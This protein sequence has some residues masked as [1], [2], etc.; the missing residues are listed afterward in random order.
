MCGAVGG[1][2]PS[3]C[4]FGLRLFGIGVFVVDVDL[5]LMLEVSLGFSLGRFAVPALEKGCSLPFD[6]FLG[7]GHM[8]LERLFDPPAESEAVGERTF[9]SEQFGVGKEIV[10][11]LRGV[12]A[13]V[14]AELGHQCAY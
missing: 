6:T 12:R 14:S 11:W 9:G 8:N 4:S 7:T 13:T 1:E 10:F 3:P 2:R 5:E